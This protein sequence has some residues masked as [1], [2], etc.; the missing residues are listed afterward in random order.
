MKRLAVRS[1]LI[2]VLNRNQTASPV[3][4]RYYEGGR[5]AGMTQGAHDISPATIDEVI[6]GSTQVTANNIDRSVVK[7]RAHGQAQPI[8]SPSCVG[9][10]CSSYHPC[11][12]NVRPFIPRMRFFFFFS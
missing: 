4:A 3:G 2:S 12:V 5:E 8:G 7:H 6:L 1:S 11:G 9:K 10:W